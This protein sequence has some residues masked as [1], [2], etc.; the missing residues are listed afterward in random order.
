[1]TRDRT[2]AAHHH[3]NSDMDCT[4]IKATLSAL[5]DGEADQALAHE[6]ERH[7]SGC[8]AC[9][10]LIDEAEALDELVGAHVG[11]M[12]D[13]AG[14]P[15]GFAEAVL[16]RTALARAPRGYLLQ[17]TTWAGWLAAAAALALAIT[18]WVSDRRQGGPRA[19]ATPTSEVTTAAYE[20]GSELRSLVYNGPIL[21]E[22]S[23][24]PTLSREDAQTLSFAA[25]LLRSV[26]AADPRSFEDIE[27]VRA[28]IEYEDLLT[29]L[30]RTRR[31]LAPEDWL[32]VMA[33]ES[34]F[35]RI[36][37]G[38]LDQD[39]V[40]TLRDLVR[41]M[42]LAQTIDAMSDRPAPGGSA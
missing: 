38:P 36:A 42:G 25:V 22:P 27:R 32:P 37:M 3:R 5:L 8:R 29:D 12:I 40:R 39:D 26:A 17:W 20:T 19:I 6:A 1:M 21:P 18:I 41:G 4:D 28:A 23:G 15:A 16:E 30:A 7:L 33:A 2:S 9:R 14:L 31:M 35:V 13:R 34:V 10:E 11:A 24:G